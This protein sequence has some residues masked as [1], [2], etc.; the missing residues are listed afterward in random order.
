MFVTTKVWLNTGTTRDKITVSMNG[1][2]YSVN[3]IRSIINYSQTTTYIL[4]TLF[5]GLIRPL[6]TFQ[7]FLVQ[8]RLVVNLHSNFLDKKNDHV[9]RYDHY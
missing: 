4:N 1:A 3:C 7:V 8:S 5:L 9:F 6:T 2:E